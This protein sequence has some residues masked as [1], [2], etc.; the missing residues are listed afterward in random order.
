MKAWQKYSNVYASIRRINIVTD[1]SPHFLYIRNKVT[2]IH[3]KADC[4]FS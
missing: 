1:V 2:V 3:R 4:I